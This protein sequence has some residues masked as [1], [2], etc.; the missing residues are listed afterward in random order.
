MNKRYERLANLE[1]KANS[2]P[3]SES[4]KSL[5]IAA[6]PEETDL[7]ALNKRIGAPQ[8]DKYIIELIRRSGNNITVSYYDQSLQYSGTTLIFPHPNDEGALRIFI[9]QIKDNDPARPFTICDLK[10]LSCWFNSM[11]N[12]VEDPSMNGCYFS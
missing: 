9:N 5:Y 6:L 11:I 1:A 10:A 8:H 3:R 4:I 12:K 7:E 2:K